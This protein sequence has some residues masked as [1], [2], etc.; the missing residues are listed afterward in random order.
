MEQTQAVTDSLLPILINL[1]AVG[2]EFRLPGACVRS[3]A[4]TLSMPINKIN[5]LIDKLK[6]VGLCFE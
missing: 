2:Y 1:L 6:H 4:S 3:T 5:Y